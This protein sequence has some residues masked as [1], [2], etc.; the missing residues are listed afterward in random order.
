M[1]GTHVRYSRIVV[2][3]SADVTNTGLQSG[4]QGVAGAALAAGALASLISG[5]AAMSVRPLL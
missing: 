1:S 4:V 3:L 5:P 2:A